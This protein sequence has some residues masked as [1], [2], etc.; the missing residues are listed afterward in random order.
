MLN[1]PAEM[2][3]K[4]NFFFPVFQ[5]FGR[6]EKF[7]LYPMNSAIKEEVMEEPTLAAD[8]IQK[9]PSLSDLSDPDNSLGK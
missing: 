8:S 1:L 4:M 5:T 3:R 6:I 9:V 7:P 2:F